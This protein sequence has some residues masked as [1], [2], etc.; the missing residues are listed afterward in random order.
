MREIRIGEFCLLRYII[1]Y[2]YPGIKTIV[3]IMVIISFDSKGELNR[4]GEQ[5]FFILRKKRQYTR[6]YRHDR[7]QRRIERYHIRVIDFRVNRRFRRIRR[8]IPVLILPF[9]FF[10]FFDFQITRCSYKRIF[11]R[12]FFTPSI[13]N[14]QI[15]LD[16]MS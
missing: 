3:M 7:L 12:T 9:P 14:E 8:E 6:Y 1:V 5:I 4:K 15:I 2:I 13:G 11:S 10:F 16:L